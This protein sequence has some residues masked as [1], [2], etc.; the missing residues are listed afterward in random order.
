[1]A[2]V[3]GSNTSLMENDDTN[4]KPT[5]LDDPA[6]RNLLAGFSAA[7]HFPGQ[8]SHQIAKKTIVAKPEKDK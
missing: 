8:H 2:E 1:M 4:V 6:V 3:I 7:L 5:G